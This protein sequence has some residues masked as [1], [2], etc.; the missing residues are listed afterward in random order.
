MTSNREIKD[1][2]CQYCNTPIE[3]GFFYCSDACAVKMPDLCYRDEQGVM[4]V[5]LAA[6]DALYG[7]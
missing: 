3:P 1:G 6:L 7:D 2:M 5:S 4:R